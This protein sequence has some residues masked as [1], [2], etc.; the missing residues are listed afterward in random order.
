MLLLSKCMALTI[1]SRLLSSS[2]T[3]NFIP[4]SR[5]SSCW[6]NKQSS[7]FF[8]FHSFHC[9]CCCCYVSCP[10]TA[11]AAAIASGTDS[12][13]Q[14]TRTIATATTLDAMNDNIPESKKLLRKSIR[15]K[16]ASLHPNEISQQSQLV[17]DKVFQLP[18][19]QSSQSIGL[20]LSMPSGEIHTHEACEKVLLDGKKL[21]LPRVGL[22]FEQCD[23]DMVQVVVDKVLLQA[24]NA[25]AAE[26][27]V[28]RTEKKMVF[29]QDWP[30]N[31]W[32]IPE[33]PPLM[34]PKGMSLAQPGDID[35]M[36]VPGLGFDGLGGRLG[37][38]K[39]YYDRFLMKMIADG[40]VKRPFLVAVG[41]EPSLVVEEEG[42]IPMS[43]Q[44]VRMDVVVVP[45]HDVF[46]CDGPSS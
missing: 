23:M 33:P 30:R 31:K 3:K 46:V 17:W 36:I 24:E 37:Q 45:H 41:L 39:G 4:L 10:S 29:Y 16:L 13:C 9:C 18:Q 8:L 21:Y 11:I 43:D 25:A 7:S 5:L 6:N 15:S 42:R 40:A 22:D 20:F 27:G 32:G 26:V 19:Y 1:S 34:D 2:T 35:L 38:G 44:D 12:I 28:E 14:N